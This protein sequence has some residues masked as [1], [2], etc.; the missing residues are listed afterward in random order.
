MAR[1]SK[2]L[3]AV[4]SYVNDRIPQANKL[5]NVCKIIKGMDGKFMSEKEIS[6]LLKFSE[7]QSGYYGDALRFLDLIETFEHEGQA[8]IGL[9]KKGLMILNSPNVCDALAEHI[10]AGDYITE[11]ERRVASYPH[12]ST[13]T[14]DRRKQSLD[15]WKKWILTTGVT[16]E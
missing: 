1:Y 3:E 13:K 5:D 9:N 4:T 15:A 16:N 11:Y 10:V 12:S 14:Q 6:K 7:R 2:T 8:M